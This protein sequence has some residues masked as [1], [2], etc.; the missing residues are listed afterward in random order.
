MN[1]ATQPLQHL[2]FHFMTV[3][4]CL[5]SHCIVADDKLIHRGRRSFLTA[6]ICRQTSH[7]FAG[8]GK[9]AVVPLICVNHA[10]RSGLL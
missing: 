9:I 8:R 5:E 7:N 4:L 2:V 6:C 10:P 1:A 3:I